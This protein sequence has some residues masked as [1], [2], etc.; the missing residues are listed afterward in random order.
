MKRS[1]DRSHIREKYAY[2]SI[3]YQFST[4]VVGKLNVIEVDKFHLSTFRLFKFSYTK[5]TSI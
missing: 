3:V 4:R 2:K 5:A 1:V